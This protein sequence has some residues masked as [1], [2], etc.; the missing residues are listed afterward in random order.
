MRLTRAKRIKKT[1]M[2]LP[3]TVVH[4]TSPYPTVD[5]VTSIRYTHSQY[6]RCCT[7]AKFKKKSPEF[8]TCKRDREHADIAVT[9]VMMVWWMAG[10]WRGRTY[11]SHKYKEG[12][13]YTP[14]SCL[15]ID[16]AIADS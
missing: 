13:E 4:T 16:V 10:G 1:I 7:L 8:S 9:M 12:H 14:Q 2:T 6:V 3:R 15:R 11:Q 5:M